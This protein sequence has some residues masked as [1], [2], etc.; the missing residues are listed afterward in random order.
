MSKRILSSNRAN[1]F[2][3]NLVSLCVYLFASPTNVTCNS[4]LWLVNNCCGVLTF[5]AE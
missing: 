1:S 2:V 4:L 5:V 3:L